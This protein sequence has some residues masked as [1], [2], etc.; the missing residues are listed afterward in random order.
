MKHRMGARASQPLPVGRKGQPQN[1][2]ELH[3]CTIG[4]TCH[5]AAG[6]L[7]STTTLQPPGGASLTSGAA[8]PHTAQSAL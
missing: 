1:G 6:C 2:E 5:A 8:Q 4:C 3:T 7:G